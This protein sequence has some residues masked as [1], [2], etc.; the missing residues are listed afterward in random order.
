LQNAKRFNEIE[1]QLNNKADKSDLLKLQDDLTKDLNEYIEAILKN[2]VNYE[3]FE[4]KIAQLVKKIREILEMISKIE[5]SN[6]DDAMFTK[7]P[8]G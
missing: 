1:I 6:E 4:K 7:R 3:V 5:P 2:F 8:F